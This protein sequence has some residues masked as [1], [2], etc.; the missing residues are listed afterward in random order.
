MMTGGVITYV[1]TEVA[2]LAI[3]G[4]MVKQARSVVVQ[5]VITVAKVLALI[6]DKIVLQDTDVLRVVMSFPLFAA[7]VNILMRDG[8]TVVIVQ[9]VN[10]VT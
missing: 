5:V 2:T 1:T 7:R 3:P 6:Q 10:A 8:V 9:Q 4:I